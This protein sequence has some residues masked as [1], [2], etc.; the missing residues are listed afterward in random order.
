V[1]NIQVQ[2]S[3][4]N[5]LSINK[6]FK[7]DGY[8]VKNITIN[9]IPTLETINEFNYVIITGGD[10][11]IRRTIKNFRDKFEIDNIPPIILN[12]T[13]SFNVIVKYYRPITIDKI[14]KKL[15][16]NENLKTLKAPIYAID[17]KIFLFSVGNSGDVAHIFISEVL[18]FGY[19]K[20]GFIRYAISMLVLMPF[21]LFI[22]PFLLISK[23][24]FFVFT[25]FGF[26]KKFFN[27]YGRVDEDIEINLG[28]YYNV[29]EFDGDLSVVKKQHITIKRVGSIDLVIG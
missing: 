13:G 24:R 28:N 1:P 15:I 18:R 25:P 5:I 29:L 2:S 9:E 6:E 8:V 10:G 16:T 19:L 14:I 3:L 21:H 7:I 23:Q 27:I 4:L 22:T 20:S 26:F 17:K 11:A 12:P